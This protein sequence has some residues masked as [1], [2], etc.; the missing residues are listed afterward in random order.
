[1]TEVTETQPLEAQDVLDL[2]DD[3]V[4]RFGSG[5]KASCIYINKANEPVCLVGHIAL[6]LG[7]TPETLRTEW[8]NFPVRSL[9]AL[10]LLFPVTSEAAELLSLAQWM[11]DHGDSWGTV[12]DLAKKAHDSTM[13]ELKG[14]KVDV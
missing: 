8:R 14:A 1:M 13:L 6:K 3:L 7:V 4:S 11:Q 10:G 12:R 9:R 2:L 5:H